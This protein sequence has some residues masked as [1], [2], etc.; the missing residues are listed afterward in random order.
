M[1]L[2]S[3]EQSA[4]LGA[5]IKL[6]KFV[7]G[8]NEWLYTSAEEEWTYEGDTYEMLEI[9]HGPI[10]DSNRD[11]VGTVEIEVPLDSAL[12]ALFNESTPSGIVDVTIYSVMREEPAADKIDFIGEVQYGD[13][14][15]SV[16]VLKCA[17]IMGQLAST[18][19]RGSHERN[20]CM[21][22]PYEDDTC[23]LDVAD[24]TFSGTVSAISPNGLQV[25]VP[26]ADAFVPTITGGVNRPN[27]FSEGVLVKGERRGKIRGQFLD[28]IFLDEVVPGLAVDDDVDLIAGDPRTLEVCFIYF[29]NVDRYM[30]HPLI[31]L[32]NPWTGRFRT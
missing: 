17:S 19:P 8:I 12:G 20:Q 22:F 30:A 14:S 10:P 15:G 24:F 1:S 27:Q 31:P 5:V 3:R 16:A 7:Q 26:G 2:I 21:W 25:T 9:K 32:D 23:D 11:N 28:V 13:F 18:F 6:Y 29:K 4:D